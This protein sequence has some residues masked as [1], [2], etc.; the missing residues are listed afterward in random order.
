MSD[1]A[2]APLGLRATLDAAIT[3]NGYSAKDLTVLAVQNDPFRV[4]TKARHRDGKWLAVQAAEHGLG[5]RRIH[6]RGLHYMLIGTRKPNGSA[7]TNTEEDWLWL[8]GH[9]GKAARWLGYLRFD[10]IIDARNAEPVVRVFNRREPQSYINVGV[11][12]E[13]PELGDIEP[14]VGVADFTGVQPYKLV[15]FG[16]KTSLEDV[17]API[18]K[19][20]RADLYLPTGEIS[21]TLLYRMASVGAAD[22]RRMIVLCLSDCDPAG[23]QMPAS[24][25][26]KLQAFHALQFPNLDFDVYQVALTPEQVREHGLPSTPLKATERRADKWQRAMGV[27]Q[28][29]I[30]AL[31][32]LNPRL[33]RRI[34]RDALAPFFDSTLDL[35]VMEAETA[36][37][38]QAQAALEEQ[39]GH[40][41]LESLSAEA[42]A[43]L[44]TLREEIDAINDALRVEEV[45]GLELPQLPEIPRPEIDPAVAGRNGKP[46]IS[47]DWNYTEQTRRLIIHKAYEEGSKGK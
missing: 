18:A 28:T 16:E 31:A 2:K 15:L 36:W 7:Y 19:A 5:D 42:R 21:D 26:R 27:E 46:L 17:L 33:L 43:K 3:S 39:I 9:A 6:L 20:Y 14:R 25:C 44:N 8:Q 38:E 45:A 12:V 23:W 41:Q 47:S 13:I 10:Q 30:D 29:E 34:V 1:Q 24:I 22:G 32:T 4:D 35:R 11:D 40:E 37:M